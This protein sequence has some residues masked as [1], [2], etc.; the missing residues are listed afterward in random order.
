VDQENKGNH[1]DHPAQQNHQRALRTGSE[2]RSKASSPPKMDSRRKS[3]GSKSKGKGGPRPRL[4][5]A[6]GSQTS[7]GTVA[8]EAE[9]NLVKEIEAI[10][11]NVRAAAKALALLAHSPSGPFAHQAAFEAAAIEAMLDAAEPG[12]RA[13][14]QWA[15]TCTALE[16]FR[17]FRDSA[18]QLGEALQACA[19]P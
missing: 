13:K 8:T 6:S 19:N 3:S 10:K 1:L 5:E 2:N 12:W 16:Y 9:I 4:H 18:Q 14:P 17:G 7:N 15:T 11:A